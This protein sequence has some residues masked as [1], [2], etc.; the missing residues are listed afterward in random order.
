MSAWQFA[1]VP[2]QPI[3]SELD[4]RAER[5]SDA[6]QIAMRMV[7]DGRLPA[8]EAFDFAHGVFQFLNTGTPFR[9]EKGTLEGVPAAEQI[10]FTKRPM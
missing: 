3:P 8:W 6:I 1:A 4:V 5:R 10:D 7:L 9:F 2:Q